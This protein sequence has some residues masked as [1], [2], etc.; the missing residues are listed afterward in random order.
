MTSVSDPSSLTNTVAAGD[1]AGG[2]SASVQIELLE[3]KLCLALETV[4]EKDRKIDEKDQEIKRLRQE[5]ERL[6]KRK[7]QSQ[8]TDWDLYNSD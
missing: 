3:Q 7:P 6:G 5:I 2:G 1:I 4:K 8:V